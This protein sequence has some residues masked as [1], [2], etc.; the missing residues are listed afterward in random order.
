MKKI[1]LVRSKLGLDDMIINFEQLKKSGLAVE[2]IEEGFSKCQMAF[3]VSA[4]MNTYAEA[5]GKDFLVRHYPIATKPEITDEKTP[6]DL[7][8]LSITTKNGLSTFMGISITPQNTVDFRLIDHSLLYQIP[9][10]KCHV[11]DSTGDRDEVSLKSVKGWF[12]KHTSA[13][14]NADTDSYRLD[15]KVFK[16]EFYVDIRIRID[17]NFGVRL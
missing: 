8:L 14:Y 11:A 6:Y 7:S 13:Y 5:K 9:L 12:K 4:D 15:V 16:K 10:S 2:H 1:E 3:R 17:V